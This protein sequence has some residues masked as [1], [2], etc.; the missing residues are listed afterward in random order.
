MQVR[1]HLVQLD[2][3]GPDPARIHEAAHDEMEVAVEGLE[4]GGSPSQLCVSEEH[5][6]TRKSV[7]RD[8]SECLGAAETL[9]RP[10]GVPDLLQFI[11]WCFARRALEE[12]TVGKND[13]L[14]KGVVAPVGQSPLSEGVVSG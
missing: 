5:A 4:F 10:I 3:S 1:E 6:S 14:T 12:K 8:T 11:E 2:S 7:L 9:V 13:P